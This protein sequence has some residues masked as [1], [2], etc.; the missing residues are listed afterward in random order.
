[1]SST[2]ISIEQL[3]KISRLANIELTAEEEESLLEKFNDTLDHVKLLEELNTSGVAPTY[4]VTGLMNVYS[5]D[6]DLPTTL[7]QEDVLRNAKSVKDKMFKLLAV[8]ERE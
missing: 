8:L 1:M 7:S 3:R 2:K 5:N 6:E 4:N